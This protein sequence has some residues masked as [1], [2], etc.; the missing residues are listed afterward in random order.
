MDP[1]LSMLSPVPSATLSISAE[2]AGSVARHL[3]PLSANVFSPSSK[4]RAVDGV[5]VEDSLLRLLASAPKTAVGEICTPRRPGLFTDVTVL[6]KML[7]VGVLVT[8]SC[9]ASELTTVLADV[10]LISLLLVLMVLIVATVVVGVATM[11]VKPASAPNV[12]GAGAT[13]PLD[14]PVTISEV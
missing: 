9:L 10:G 2:T 8:F 7:L 4:D 6:E 13:W 3:R 1:V 14:V 5:A 12:S 11:L